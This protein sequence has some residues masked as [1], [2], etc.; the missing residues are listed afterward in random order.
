MTPKIK[1]YDVIV[2]GSGPSGSTA[3]RILAQHSF[4]VAIIEKCKI[5]RYKPCGGG[6]VWKARK[7]LENRLEGI[8]E[9]EFSNVE[10]NLFQQALSF[11]VERNF[12]LIT[13]VMRDKLDFC[14][15]EVAIKAG[16]TLYTEHEV[17]SMINNSNKITLETSAD[18]FECKYLIGADGVNSRIAK[19]AGWKESRT[20]APALEYE[21]E[22][23]TKTFNR[24]SYQPRFDIEYLPQ[25]YAWVFP[26]KKHFSVGL[27]AIRAPAKGLHYYFQNYLADIGISNIISQTGQGW[28]IPVSP[29]KNG[30]FKNNIMLIGDAAGL[31]DPVTGEGITN[32]ILSGKIAAEAIIGSGAS[33]TAGGIY[34]DELN[35]QM[36][37]GLK[38]ARTLAKLL[39]L[40][41]WL[42]KK[43]FEKHGQQLC[44][45]VADIFSGEKRYPIYLVRTLNKFF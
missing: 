2:I 13:M 28:F 15:T 17:I 11:H 22:T 42:R 41:K 40:S 36:L 7:L 44:E 4:S 33:N 38:T 20:V 10:I 39:Y 19:L 43:V 14:L 21:I 12:P 37:K 5:P 35:T 27:M 25:G 8:I 32:A 3:A 26:K 23:D 45:I 24:L 16:A 1:K 9:N 31:A 34:Q 29:R 6:I 30:F 18:K